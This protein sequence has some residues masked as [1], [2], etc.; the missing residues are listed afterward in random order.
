MQICPLL[1]GSRAS[2]PVTPPLYA[3]YTLFLPPLK[4]S[5][6]CC[7][8]ASMVA[9]SLVPCTSREWSTTAWITLIAG[10]KHAANFWMISHLYMKCIRG[11]WS[12]SGALPRSLS[13]LAGVLSTL[14]NPS[15]LDPGASASDRAQHLA[16]QTPTSHQA[17][18]RFWRTLWW[19][20]MGKGRISCICCRMH[21]TSLPKPDISTAQAATLSSSKSALLPPIEHANAF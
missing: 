21:C 14:P 3:K 12:G 8:L 11:V 4:I 7:L 20:G 6:L 17:K 13:W 10:P 1:T 19:S 9:C 18:K 2:A 16:L 15:W 5:L